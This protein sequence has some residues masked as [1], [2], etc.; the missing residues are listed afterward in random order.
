MSKSTVRSIDRGYFQNQFR[1]PEYKH[2]GRPT[3][4]SQKQD[5]PVDKVTRGWHD[6][7]DEDGE[8]VEEE[9]EE[10]G[11]GEG[12]EEE[13]ESDVV[14]ELLSTHSVWLGMWRI[15]FQELYSW[16]SFR[17]ICWVKK[18]S[19]LTESVLEIPWCAPHPRLSTSRNP[20]PMFIYCESPPVNYL[21]IVRD[22]PQN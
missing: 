19:L 1:V 4:D 9:G 7:E 6:L 16:H 22:I 3:Q 20:D 14:R 11:E 2:V 10:E 12:E 18:M 21:F 17:A 5:E 13:E 15:F 8:K